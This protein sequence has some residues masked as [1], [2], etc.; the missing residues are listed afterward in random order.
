MKR[1]FICLLALLLLSGCGQAEV[2]APAPAETPEA[3]PPQ[4]DWARP[5]ELKAE[6][7]QGLNL[8]GVGDADDAVYI[9]QL[10][11]GDAW[12]DNCTALRVR[13]GT[14][15]TMARILPVRGYYTLQTASLF[16]EDRQALILEVQCP[17]SN[18]GAANLFVYDVFPAG[19][20]PAPSIVDRTFYSADDEPLLEAWRITDGTVPVEIGG[21]PLQGLTVYTSGAQ[22]QWREA[23]DRGLNIWSAL[24]TGSGISSDIHRTYSPHM[25]LRQSSD[26]R[27][28]LRALRQRRSKVR[29]LRAPPGSGEPSCCIRNEGQGWNAPL[30]GRRI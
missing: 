24:Q 2:S 27:V 6:L 25:R 18:W 1:L 7:I 29:I 10:Q 30:S 28:G 13:L 3:R 19:N 8:D 11:F 12:D 22:G 4:P 17:G 23:G 15:E 20:D 14:G 21:S 26:S 5:A 9:S 16:S